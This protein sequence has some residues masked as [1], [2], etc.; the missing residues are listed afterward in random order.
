MA[1]RPNGISCTYGQYTEVK[2]IHDFPHKEKDKSR[3][4]AWVRFV[5]GHR[6]NC[7]ST[8]LSVLCSDHFDDSCFT[9]KRKIAVKLGMKRKLKPDVV[10]TIDFSLT[11]KSIKSKI[12]QLTETADNSDHSLTDRAKRQ[13]RLCYIFAS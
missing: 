4:Q 3:H 7:S 2:S 13:V 9:N 5:R 1:G 11:E 10:P 6:P 8:S 12:N